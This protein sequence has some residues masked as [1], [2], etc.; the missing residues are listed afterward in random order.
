MVR[1]SETDKYCGPL[2]L[3]GDSRVAILCYSR[4]YCGLGP[5]S[6]TELLSWSVVKAWVFA[7][8]ILLRPFLAEVAYESSF[9]SANSSSSCA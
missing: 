3:F 8:L 1:L 2:E 5:T 6:G 4:I 7:S 9:T